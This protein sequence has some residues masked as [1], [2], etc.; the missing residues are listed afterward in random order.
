MT[1]VGEGG[2]LR[3]SAGALRLLEAGATR[4][5]T[6]DVARYLERM[7][8]HCPYL[9]PSA[10]RELTTWTV[11]QAAGDRDAVEAEL[12]HACAREAERLRTLLRR[13]YGLLRCENVVLLG[14]V[15]GVSHRDL[16]AWPHWALKNLYSSV[17]IM[18]GKFCAGEEEDTRSGARTPA[19]PVSFLPVRAAIRRRDPYFL[20][21]EPDLATALAT[22]HDDGR[23]VF[24][25]LSHD[26][27]E[28]RTWARHLLPPAKPLPPS[29]TH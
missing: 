10:E 8:V 25:P 9:A 4:P 21:A 29:A 28:I 16:F 13:P 15:P 24:E 11:Y 14:E 2:V 18:F 23:D 5:R 27:T 17:G 1:T 19:A 22:A 20:R 6:I 3:P 26:W 7:S 12:F